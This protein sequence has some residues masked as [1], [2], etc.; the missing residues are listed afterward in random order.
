MAYVCQKAK[1]ASQN[2]F[3]SLIGK[4]STSVQKEIENDF[5]HLPLGCSIVLEKK[6]KDIILE[7][8][9]NSTSLNVNQIISK[10]IN[11]KHQTSLPLTLKNFLEFNHIQL[12]TIYKNSCW[13]RL[14]QKAG[15][16]NDYEIVH[17]KQITTAIRKKW[18]STSSFSYFQFILN[19]AKNN[20][21]VDVK[22]LSENEKTMLLML[23][24]D[25]WQKPSSFRNLEE[26]IK[27]IG[28]NKVLTNE[29]VELIEI[30]IDQID[31]KEIDID[32][33]YSQPLKIHARYTRDQILVAFKMSTFETP[34]SNRIGVGVAENKEINTEILFID[35]V[36][37]EEDYSPTTMYND[38]AISESLF[39]WQSQNQ[40]RDDIGKGL[41]Y[42]KH[43]ETGKKIL[44]FI[45]EKSK[46]E[47]GNTM[48]YVFVGEGT[49]RNYEGSKPMSIKWEL[50]EPLPHYLWKESAKMAI[51]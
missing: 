33:P 7:N 42:I 11:F 43:Q 9:R 5:P 6:A 1:I 47:F 41:T 12:A 19:L 49:F 44:L 30:L 48:G 3:R 34:S 8:I 25:V 31:F 21:L 51:G 4:T 35:L 13:S 39:H 50:N 38:F 28:K 24:Y 17:E 23:S 36:K 15:E 37:S 26:S 45:R 29:I 46:N 22:K 20:F 2:K 14:C 18:L 32:L 10:I 40:T 16:I 27:E